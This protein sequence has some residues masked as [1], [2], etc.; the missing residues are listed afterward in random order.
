MFLFEAR[1]ETLLF[2]PL[3]SFLMSVYHLSVTSS[4]LS[5]HRSPLGGGGAREGVY[6]PN[7]Q[8]L[9]FLACN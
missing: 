2:S 7:I 1:T 3:E 5:T 9:H 6:S 8:M 4:S